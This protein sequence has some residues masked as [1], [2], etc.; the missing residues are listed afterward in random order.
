MGDRTPENTMTVMPDA[1]RIA[2]RHRRVYAPPSPDYEPAHPFNGGGGGYGAG[3][4]AIRLHELF[5]AD[6]TSDTSQPEDGS[7]H[8]FPLTQPHHPQQL[9]HNNANDDDEEAEADTAST[10]SHATINTEQ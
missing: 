5:D 2:N 7:Q 10:F 3:N 9:N 6:M 8:L 4:V 1:P